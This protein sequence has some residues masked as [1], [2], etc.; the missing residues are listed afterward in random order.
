MRARRLAAGQRRCWLGQ[1]LG[2]LQFSGD[3]IVALFLEFQ[4]EFFVAGFH[5]AA[6]TEHVHKVGDDVVE[7]ALVV[8]D[9]E[10]RVVL[11]LQV[12]DPA[13]HD[14]ERIAIQTRISLVKHGHGR[15]QQGHLKN[16]GAFLLAT[17]KALV[18]RALEK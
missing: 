17:G 11:T 16:L 7:Q 5:D 10:L 8:R 4:R 14:L 2:S 15:F 9:D 1:P 12:I 13:G 18:Y 3:P 6:I